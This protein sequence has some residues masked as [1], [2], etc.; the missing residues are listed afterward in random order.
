MRYLT[1]RHAL[2]LVLLTLFAASA[3]PALAQYASYDM[4]FSVTA[5]Y[6]EEKDQDLEKRVMETLR[7]QLQAKDIEESEAPDWIF[8]IGAAKLEESGQVVLSVVTMYAL[9]EAVV[10]MGRQEEA[11]YLNA[12]DEE[13]AAFP[14]EGAHVRQAMSE[15]FMRQFAMAQDQDLLMVEESA[16]ETAIAEVVERFFARHTRP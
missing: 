10:Q 13:R 9:P 1:V 14:K 15:D 3:S 2:L 7:T 16:L 8:L 12:S 5:A 4:T 11:F 6:G